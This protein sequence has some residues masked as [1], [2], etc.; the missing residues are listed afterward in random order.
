MQCINRLQCVLLRVCAHV[1]MCE[2]KRKRDM[3]FVQ[4]S[5][6]NVHVFLFTSGN[7][8]HHN[9]TLVVS[10]SV[11]HCVTIHQGSITSLWEQYLSGLAWL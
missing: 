6:C 8:L 1:R 2:R 11:K 10:S 3:R 7:F 4:T 5:A 9:N